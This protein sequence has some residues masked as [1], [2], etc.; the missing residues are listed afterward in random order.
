[1]L[2]EVLSLE[3]ERISIL[4]Y[5]RRACCWSHLFFS[6]FSDNFS[7]GSFYKCSMLVFSRDQSMASV[8]HMPGMLPSL[9]LF[10]S[11]SHCLECS[12]Q[13]YLLGYLLTP[14]KALHSLLQ[15]H[16]LNKPHPDHLNQYWNQ[17]PTGSISEPTCPAPLL[18]STTLPNL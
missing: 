6:Y 12:S 4:N 14:F 3:I 8:S 2:T 16:L 7:M 10:S 15:C 13:K 1:M 5:R 9:G 18:C 17:S 11:C